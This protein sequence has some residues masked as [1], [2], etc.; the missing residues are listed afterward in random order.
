M[1]KTISL[2]AVLFAFIFIANAQFDYGIKAGLSFNTNGELKNF[3]NDV[4]KVID[5]K[6]SAKT[7]FNVGFY[8]KIDL[9]PVFIR[10]E[11][12][13]TRTT[14]EYTIDQHKSNFNTS[15]LDL[16]VLLGVELVGPLAIMAGPAF[17]YTLNNDFTAKELKYSNIKNKFTAGLNIGLSAHFGKLG[18]D[19]RYERGFSK[20]EVSFINKNITDTSKYTLDSRP[21]QFIVS[22]SYKLN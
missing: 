5:T 22:L 18:V 1:R 12:V 9:G 8:S 20:N 15:R 11:L 21:Q 19:A 16:P 6:G 10:P 7:G 17:Q 4:E 13:Y 3:I 2:V 14:S